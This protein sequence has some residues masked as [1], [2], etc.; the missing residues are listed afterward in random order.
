MRNVEQVRHAFSS[1]KVGTV[2]RQAILNV[3][4]AYEELAL[5]ILNQTPDCPD[6]TAALRKLLES[7]WTCTHAISH[8]QVQS[9]S[10]RPQEVSKNAQEEKASAS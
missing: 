1:Q 10:D 3:E 9:G 7:K 8:V 4:K 5:T 6:R 2:E